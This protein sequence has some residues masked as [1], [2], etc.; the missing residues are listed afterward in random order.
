[1][2]SVVRHSFVRFSSREVRLVWGNSHDH[3]DAVKSFMTSMSMMW[4]DRGHGFGQCIRNAVGKSFARNWNQ[5][6]K[7]DARNPLWRR[8]DRVI[9]VLTVECHGAIF[10]SGQFPGWLGRLVHIWIANGPTKDLEE[11]FVKLLCHGRRSV[12]PII[13]PRICLSRNGIIDDNLFKEN[14]M[15]LMTRHIVSIRPS[16]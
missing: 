11:I 16:Q 8:N 15:S 14:P 3:S 5:E 1:L 6:T 13:P 4:R 7:Q 12:G 10:D 2:V 9:F